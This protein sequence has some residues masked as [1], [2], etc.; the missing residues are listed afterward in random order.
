MQRIIFFDGHCVLCDGFVSR[1]FKI[2]KKHIFNFASLQSESG[3]K[4][5]SQQDLGSDSV[6]YFENKQTYTRSAA[7]LR[8]LFQLGGFYTLLSLVFSVLPTGFRDWLYNKI[9][10]NR[11]RI[12][13]FNEVCRIPT[14]EEKAYFLN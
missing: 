14:D 13:G 2:D 7:V 8:I 1:V 10:K 3:A 5:L 6:V 12:F 4:L 11:Y 9:A